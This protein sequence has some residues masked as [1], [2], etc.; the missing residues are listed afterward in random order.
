MC[1]S[2][3]ES[4]C[5]CA[6]C[7]CPCVCGMCVWGGPPPVTFLATA[8]YPHF[9]WRSRRS[10]CWAACCLRC[11]CDVMNQVIATCP[12][13]PGRLDT[14]SKTPTPWHHGAQTTSR[15]AR[16]WCAGLHV[17][18]VA[19]VPHG[20]QQLT[21][22]RTCCRLRSGLCRRRVV[23]WRGAGVAQVWCCAA[24]ACRSA[25]IDP[26]ACRV[27]HPVPRC[28]VVPCVS[29]CSW[30]GVAPPTLPRLRTSWTSKTPP[31]ASPTPP[32]RRGARCG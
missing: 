23:L 14:T 13:S 2:E 28:V 4:V 18:R 5:V 10:R 1:V 30:T 27:P 7:V 19:R 20:T 24:A 16:V 31:P 8:S 26:T 25:R 6:V 11:G 22:A 12:S 29:S 17:C 15:C 9:P 21:R 32:T 3:R